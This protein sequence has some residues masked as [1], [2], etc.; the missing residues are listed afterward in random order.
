MEV[1]SRGRKREK[2]AFVPRDKRYGIYPWYKPR[3]K[4]IRSRY[5]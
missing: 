5:F 4:G 2:A 3:E 1:T